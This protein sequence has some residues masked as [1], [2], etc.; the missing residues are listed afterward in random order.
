LRV[1]QLEVHVDLSIMSIP[2]RMPVGHREALAGK[3]LEGVEDIG[4]G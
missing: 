1:D 4:F 2:R 3:L